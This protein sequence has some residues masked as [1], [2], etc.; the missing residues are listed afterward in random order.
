M[1]GNSIYIQFVGVFFL[2]FVFED[3][4]SVGSLGCPG[5]YFVDQAGLGFKEPTAFIF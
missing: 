4:T 1:Q 2:C 5:T 3:R